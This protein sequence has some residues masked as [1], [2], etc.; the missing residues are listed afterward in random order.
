MTTVPPLVLIE[1]YAHRLG[2]HHP[3]TL[4][5]LAAARPGALVVAPH[6]AAD[7]GLLRQAGARLV[8]GTRGPA[9]AA[10]LAA[11][12]WANA[13]SAAGRK[14]FASRRW[15]VA[16]QRAPHQV[17]LLA[18]CLTEAACLRTARHLVREPAAVVVLSASEALH[19]ATALL[20]GQPHL[21]F[22]HEAVTTEDT[23]VRLLGRLARRGERRVVALYPTAAVRHQF[24]GA[25]PGLA[26][27]ARAFAVDDGHRLTDA[28]RDSAR[29]AFGIPDGATVVCL[30]GGWWP[31][32]DI[33]TVNAALARLTSPLHLVVTGTPLDEQ[34]LTRWHELPQVH[35]H[36]VPGPVGEQV[37]RLVYAA[38]DAALVARRPGVGKES[39]LV[40]D[41]ARLGVPLLLSG[42]DPDLTA[43]LA[44]QPWAR[45]FPVGDPGALAA[46][47]DAL[48]TG[49]PPRPGPGAPAVLGMATAAEQAA[50]LTTAYTRLIEELR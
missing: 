21:R 33:A 36:T 38:A 43:R 32:K 29:T 26:G 40:M 12:Q 37:L 18:R 44:G 48:A 17:T 8:T 28:E 46:V 49:L 47:L 9:A 1:P 25:F 35:L 2:G 16:L 27:V 24:A 31:Y 11:A 15:P 34:V 4:A 14:A 22:I 23:P 42:H 45:L 3:R 13:V 6:G 20:G 5:A 30:V 19:G 10:L 7:P 50:F 41:T 39:G